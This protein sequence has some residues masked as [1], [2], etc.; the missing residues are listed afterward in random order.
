V[1]ERE[2][3][4]TELDGLRWYCAKCNTITLDHRFRCADLGTQLKTFITDYY[5]ENG[6][7]KRTCKQCGTVDQ[8]PVPKQ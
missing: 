8:R 6:L 4:G 2:R 1:L 7:S 5:S 3:W